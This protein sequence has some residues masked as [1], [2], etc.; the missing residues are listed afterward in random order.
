MTHTQTLPRKTTCMKYRHRDTHMTQ[1]HTLTFDPNPQLAKKIITFWYSS[2][3]RIFRSCC[4][5]LS[6]S[7]LSSIHCW[8]KYTEKHPCGMA[9]SLKL[10]PHC[11]HSHN[12][13][14][15]SISHNALLQSHSHCHRCTAIWEYF[16]S[17]SQGSKLCLYY[18]AQLCPYSNIV[19]G[20]A[21]CSEHQIDIN[22][23]DTMQHLTGGMIEGNVSGTQN[24]RSQMP[25][26]LHAW[27]SGLRTDGWPS[28]NLVP[29]CCS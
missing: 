29:K 21:K 11:T 1:T 8:L 26:V 24:I 2:S 20:Q 27:S 9:T 7:C 14:Y 3:V 23:V 12:H 17:I 13:I 4:R 22:L 19:Q 25:K 16:F 6:R 5:S 10:L 15:I 28:V 18:P